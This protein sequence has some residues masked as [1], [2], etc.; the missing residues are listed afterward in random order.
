M[1]NSIETN[2]NLWLEINPLLEGFHITY[3]AIGSA[4]N[5]IIIEN[6]DMVIQ[7]YPKF[8]SRINNVNK[9]IW[10]IDENLDTP[11]TYLEKRLQNEGYI[12]D[13]SI[14]LQSVNGKI[15]RFSKNHQIIQIIIIRS[16]N[17]WNKNWNKQL[18]IAELAPHTFDLFSKLIHYIYYNTYSIM[19]IQCYNGDTHTD[20]EMQIDRWGMNDRI[21]IG[22]SQR[23]YTS[24]YINE[25]YLTDIQIVNKKGILKVR[26]PYNIPVYKVY[27]RLTKYTTAQSFKL[28]ITYMIYR[29]IYR[30]LMN[31]ANFTDFLI[32]K[33][34]RNE[35]LDFDQFTS[36][37]MD[38]SDRQN[39]YK[40]YINESTREIAIHKCIELFESYFNHCIAHIDTYDF[41]TNPDETFIDRVKRLKCI[42]PEKINKDL[43]ETVSNSSLD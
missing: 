19:F 3:L 40:D 34:Q 42:L 39:I 6:N 7:Q 38:N 11:Q 32:R 29:K 23:S 14:N 21:I 20:L 24:C 33:M 18:V 15:I 25:N 12:E 2:N 10:L 36:H 13:I 43:L 4:E 37:I 5:G 30:N 22:I 8:L 9:C 27:H 35:L 1:N 17:V 28:Q 31:A 41:I 26:N 16:N